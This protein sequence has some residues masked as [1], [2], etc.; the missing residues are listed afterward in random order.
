MGFTL[1]LVIL[2]VLVSIA[3]FQNEATMN[4][5]MLWPRKM[6]NAAEYYRLLTSGFIHAD[7]GHLIFNMIALYSFG[8]NVESIFAY[9]GMG[10]GLFVMLYLTSIVVAS[11][12]SF[13]K[14]KN[15][16]FYRSLGASGGV[17]AI[18]F[19]SVYFMPWNKI[20]LIFIPIPGILAAVGFLVYSATMSKKGNDNIGHDAHFWGAVY[21]FVF[22]LVFAPDHGRMFLEQLMHPSFF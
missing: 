15:N 20:Y 17:S 11:L 5:L 8:Q 6:D 16:S 4:K 18:I 7:W 21:G 12:P 19:S 9:S 3:A 13:I 10:T 14:H 2:T 22:T 1:I